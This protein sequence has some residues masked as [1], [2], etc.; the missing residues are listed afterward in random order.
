MKTINVGLDV[1]GVIDAYPNLFKEATRRWERAGHEI[2]ILTGRE[3]DLVTVKLQRF[4]ITYHHIFSIVDYNLGIGT[5]M[6]NND[7]RGSGWWME[8]D[9]W[10]KSKGIYCKQVHLDVHFDNEASYI[11][12]FPDYCTFVLVPPT[13]FADLKILF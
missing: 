3:T 2:H 4:E 10:I 1:H 5:K 11:E 6:W 12:W 7:S 13:G 9:L 8:D